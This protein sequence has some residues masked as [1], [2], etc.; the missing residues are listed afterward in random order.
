MWN[1]YFDKILLPVYAIFFEYSRLLGILPYTLDTD[2]LTLTYTDHGK[3][4]M[5]FELNAYCLVV[6]MFTIV[7]L[8]NIHYWTGFEFETMQGSKYIIAYWFM[9]AMMVVSM[10]YSHARHVH[11]FARTVSSFLKFERHIIRGNHNQITIL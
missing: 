5:F 11:N 9:C 1:Q 10:L 7:T 6:N 3:S 2:T 4:F 8:F